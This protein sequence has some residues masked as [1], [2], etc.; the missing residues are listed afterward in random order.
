M[1]EDE[2]ATNDSFFTIKEL[3]LRNDSNTANV[4][5]YPTPLKQNKTRVLVLHMWTCLESFNTNY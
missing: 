3:P 2:K 5:V 4:L 1:K